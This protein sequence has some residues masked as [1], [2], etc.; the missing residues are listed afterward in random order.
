MYLQRWHPYYQPTSDPSG[1]HGLG[2]YNK[3]FFG[4]LGSEDLYDYELEAGGSQFQSFVM[5]W[6]EARG[7]RPWGV[8]EWDQQQR[9]Q[10]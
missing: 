7:F 10:V 6:A 4:K 5:G 2:L 1:F 3:P 9:P 8:K